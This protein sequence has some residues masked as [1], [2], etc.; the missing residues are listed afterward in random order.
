MKT[1]TIGEAKNELSA[2]LRLVRRGESV[3]ILN[4]KRPVARLEPVT[5]LKD[6]ERLAELERQGV[7]H[8]GGGKLPDYLWKTKPVK[9]AS[10]TSVLNAL[11]EERREGR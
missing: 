6:E 2:L 7:I 5:L 8:R 10:G 1:V 4:R 3:L 9:P 11:L